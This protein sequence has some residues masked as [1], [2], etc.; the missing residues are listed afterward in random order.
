MPELLGVSSRTGPAVRFFND[1]R[2]SRLIKTFCMR[3]ILLPIGRAALDQM[4]T[5]NQAMING[6]NST[7]KIADQRRMATTT[8]LTA[9]EHLWLQKEIENRAHELWRAG[10]CRP[11]LTLNDWLQ[12]EREIAE[13]FFR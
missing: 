11:N 1:I 3:M 8:S 9:D 6:R 7:M 10:G 5:T 12:A 4:K 2:E 13:K